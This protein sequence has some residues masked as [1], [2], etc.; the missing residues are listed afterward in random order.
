MHLNHLF[1][2]NTSNQNNGAKMY[3]QKKGYFYYYLSFLPVL[4]A[5]TVYGENLTINHSVKIWLT[6]KLPEDSVA[7]IIK[8]TYVLSSIEQVHK[9]TLLRPFVRTKKID[10]G[11]L[12][13]IKDFFSRPEPPY[14]FAINM[15]FKNKE[16][17]KQYI[18]NPIHTNYH[19]KYI[20]PYLVKIVVHD[21]QIISIK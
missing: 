6:E 9:L 3:F 15:K 1:S 20:K 12:D 16:E 8:E 4:F 5:N 11:I 21:S 18:K 14:V 13:D 2:I 19:N 17:L 7:N 10:R